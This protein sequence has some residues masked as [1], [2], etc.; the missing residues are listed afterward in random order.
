MLGFLQDA[1]Y[2][3][4]SVQ[5]VI[6]GKRAAALALTFDDGYRHLAEVLPPL[7]ELFNIRPLILI[8][9]AFIGKSN[10]WDYCHV[11]EDT[12]HLNRSEIRRLASLGVE[13]GS[14]GH[15]HIALTQCTEATRHNELSQSRCI[16]E[17]ITGSPVT[18]ISYPFGRFND[19]VVSAA[20]EA[21]YRVGLTMRMPGRDDTPMALGRLPVYSFD[22]RISVLRKV[23]GGP[24]LGI[25]NLKVRATNLLS[26]GTLILNRLRR[27]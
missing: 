3:F 10:S 16:L 27:I 21:G 2:G 6:H 18:V 7:I 22:S 14:H 13:F 15:R 12:P 19:R 11:F 23:R 5:D 20:L 24:L 26:V 17:E 8:P 4:E 9:T 1:G 25:E